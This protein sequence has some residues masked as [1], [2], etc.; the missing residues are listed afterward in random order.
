[1]AT[2][3][4]ET[5][6]RVSG[7]NSY[8]SEAT[9]TT[10]ATD[11]G[12]TISGD[13]AELLIQAMDYIESLEFIGLRYTEDQ[14]LEWPRSGAKKKRI[15]YYD[16]DEIPQELK[17]GLCEVALAIDADNSPLSDLERRTEREKV[18]DLEVTYGSG[19]LS[20]TVVRK[21]NAK[22]KRLLSADYGLNFTVRKA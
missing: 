19:A 13:T 17:D 15:Y 3:V 2:I 16:T 4:V 5:G 11:R 21:I 1:M 6:A 8:V 18:G 22:L 10:Y 20:A 9:L 14:E 12:V 7:A